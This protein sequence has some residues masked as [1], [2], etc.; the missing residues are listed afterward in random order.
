MENRVGSNRL[1]LQG[2]PVALGGI[3]GV[4]RGPNGLLVTTGIQGHALASQKESGSF[5]LHLCLQL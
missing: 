4:T 3:V 2:E 1:V 5:Q